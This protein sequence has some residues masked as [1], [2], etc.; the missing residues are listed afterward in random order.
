MLIRT[1]LA[2][3]RDDA[4]NVA[5][6][7]ANPLGASSNEQ[8]PMGFADTLKLAVQGVSD[9][10]SVAAQ[11]M[12][13]VDSGQSDDLVGAMLSSQEAS[14]QFSML[15]QVRNKVMSA[16]DEIVKLQL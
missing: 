1:D 12:A 2:Q 4:A 13:D 10:D 14:L 15:M 16:V 7:A 8:E 3:L 5:A 11:R 6:P 9:K